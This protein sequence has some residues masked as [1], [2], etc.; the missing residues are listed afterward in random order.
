MLLAVLQGV[1]LAAALALCVPVAVLTIQVFSATRARRLPLR[2]EDAALDRCARPDIA[3]LMPAHNEA[4][5]VAASIASVLAQLAPGDRLLVVAD[6]CT[7]DT[8]CIARSAGAAVVE[9]RDEARRGKGYALDFG[10]RALASS[11]PAVVVV[12]DS[13]CVV[14]PLAI[15]R[16]ARLSVATGRP[17][18]SL[19][20]MKS[21]TGAPLKTRIAEFAWIVKNEVRALGYHRL[22]LPCQL[23]GSGMAFPWS[24]ISTAPLA[25]GHIVEDLKLGLEL[26]ASGTPPLYCPQALV[27]S[28]FPSTAS[29][30]ASQRTRWEHG[31]LAIIVTMG[32]PLLRQAL[33]RRQGALA[34]MALDV[35]VPPLT[36]LVVALAAVL[37]VS[38]ATAWLGTPLFALLVSVAAMATLTASLAAAWRRFGRKAVSLR[39]LGT[40]PLYVLGKMP[41]YARMMWRRQTEWVRTKRDDGPR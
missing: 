11:P 19:Y 34:A 9:R 22:G 27:T 26:A 7:D 24:I 33:V 39:E 14:A 10:V 17:V 29:G 35:C 16:I 4:E 8:A 31:H 5:G 12:V 41:M 20:L 3:V 2:P 37:V 21:P 36:T 38:A 6:N 32:L 30:L 40:V 25:S 1:L 23:M 18:Q 28:V 13:D 15:D